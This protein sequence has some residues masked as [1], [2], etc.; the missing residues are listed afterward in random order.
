MKKILLFIIASL[1]IAST[2][3]AAVSVFNSAQVGTNPT[4]T[5]VLQT[6][7]TNSAWVSPSSLGISGNNFFA[8]GTP[9]TNIYPNSATQLSVGT[10]SN[11]ATFTSW[12]NGTGATRNFTFVNNA[13]TTIMEG[14]NNGQVA[15][16]SSTP[17]GQL[18]VEMN[19]MNPAFVVSHNGSSTPAF[20]VGGTAQKGVVTIGGTATFQNIVDSTN[21]VITTAG[22]AIINS[23]NSTLAI[24]VNGSTKIALSPAGLSVTS[25]QPVSFTS[26]TIDSSGRIGAGTTTPVAFVDSYTTASTTNLLLESVSGKGGCL[27][28]KD[29]G[30]GTS[31]TQIYSQGGIIFAKVATSINTCN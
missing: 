5:R 10:S 31:Y 25:G 17:W 15:L 2:V 27:I 21:V 4:N 22:G 30:S 11:F 19:G 8:T 18:N 24:Q 23:N 26:G 28:M 13:S 14:W 12:G 29:V 9:T 7:G 3:S 20:A 6:D 1:L 16:A